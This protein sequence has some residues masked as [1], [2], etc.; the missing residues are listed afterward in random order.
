MYVPSPL[1]VG[2]IVDKGDV[3]GQIG[4]TGRATG[5]HVHFFIFQKDENGNRELHDPCEFLDCDATI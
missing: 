1:A 5:P 3:I 4:M 2:T